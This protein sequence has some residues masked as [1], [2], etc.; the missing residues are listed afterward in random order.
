[1]NRFVAWAGLPDDMK[2]QVA[3]LAAAIVQDS[4]T[5]PSRPAKTVRK[6]PTRRGL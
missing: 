4:E 5:E 6:I 1:M 2:D 3:E